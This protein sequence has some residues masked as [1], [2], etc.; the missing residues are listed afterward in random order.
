MKVIPAHPVDEVAA[1][2]YHGL[3][4]GLALIGVA[5]HVYATCVHW[6]NGRRA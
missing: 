3:L 2:F 4:A 6:R 5:Y 1:S